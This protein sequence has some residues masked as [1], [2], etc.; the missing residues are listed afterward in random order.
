MISNYVKFVLVLIFTVIF[1]TT[2]SAQTVSG[3]DK[4]QAKQHFSFAVQNK[5]SENYEEAV[6]QYEKSLAL[7]STVYQV[8]YSYADMLM[9]MGKEQDARRRFLQAFNL[10]PEHYS[11][12]AMLAR[13]YYQE[14]VFDSALVMYECMYKLKPEKSEFLTVIAGLK[15]YLGMDEEALAAYNTLF[16]AGNCTFE[17]KMR[18]AKLAL[19]LGN[20]ECANK[21]A[22]S[23]LEDNP[24]DVNALKI[25][26]STGLDMGNTQEATL[27]YRKL[28]ESDA[29]SIT[30]VET[31]EKLY[32]EQSDRNGILWTL[33]RHHELAP[34]NAEVLGELAK[35]LYSDGLQERSLAYVKKGIKIA[36]NDGR[37]RI[38]MGEHY[39]ANGDNEKA[40][41]EFRIAL[42][43]DRYKSSAQS[44]IYQ[45]EKPETAEEIAEKDFFSRGN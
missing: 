35:M 27:N 29:A 45:I 5:K 43:D 36:P 12:A 20:A 23:A 40:L 9:S 17:Q 39:R 14:S 13:L 41:A 1:Y 33:E 42:N 26:A 28:A 24:D 21:Y 11:S 18:A 30:I 19:K 10:N 25:A 7:D 8:Y 6:K 44:L 3:E 31:L 32:G 38:L 34:D 2:V 16:D 15:E 22:E 37:F 4:S